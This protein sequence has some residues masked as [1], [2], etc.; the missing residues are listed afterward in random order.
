MSVGFWKEPRQRMCTSGGGGEGCWTMREWT[1]FPA[2]RFGLLSYYPHTADGHSVQDGYLSSVLWLTS[3][4]LAGSR[5][6]PGVHEKMNSEM[7]FRRVC[8]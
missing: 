8:V 5:L 2:V 3:F 1:W 6:L 4:S 7:R